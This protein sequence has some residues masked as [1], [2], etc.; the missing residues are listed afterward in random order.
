MVN[1]IEFFIHHDHLREDNGATKSGFMSLH[2]FGATTKK[3][4]APFGGNGGYGK[5]SGSATKAASAELQL[6]A[7]FFAA[8][9][10]SV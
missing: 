6:I 8:P 1:L 10:G 9:S 5:T 3:T 7:S 2:F 4:A